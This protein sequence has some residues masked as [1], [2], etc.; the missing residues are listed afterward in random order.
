MEN[1]TGARLVRCLARLR[2][3]RGWTQ[4]AFAERAGLS[5]KYYQ[6]IE[7][8]RRLDLKISTLARLAK[9]HQL[10]AGKLLELA[11]FPTAAHRLAEATTPY[12]AQP[13]K[14]KKAGKK[15]KKRKKRK[16]K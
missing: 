14:A 1:S 12:H 16:K 15:Q 6:A 4:E 9:A 2:H 10:S 5:Y 13:P 3:E 11:S 8:G 7:N